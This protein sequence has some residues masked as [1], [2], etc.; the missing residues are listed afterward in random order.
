LWL[1]TVDPSSKF[2]YAANAGQNTITAYA[3]DKTTGDLNVI[4]GEFGVS[5]SVNA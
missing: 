3:I 2:A 4:S 5:F 1:A